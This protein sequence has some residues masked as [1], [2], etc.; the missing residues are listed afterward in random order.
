ITKG[1]MPD[2]TVAKNKAT[3]T[4]VDMAAFFDDVDLKQHSMV[5]FHT[6]AGNINVELF[7]DTA[8]QTVANF[9]N[10]VTSNQ[11]DSSIF[12]RLPTGFVLQGGG[13]SYNEDLRSITSI[14]N[15]PSVQNEFDGVNRSNLQGTIAMAKLPADAPG[16]GPNSATNQ[17]FFNLAN[18]AG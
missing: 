7:D 5:R 14:F 11:Y 10:Y 15:G 18:N 4:F 8:P 1:T 12:H 13:F 6:S 16:G 3:D 9:L 2:V 17:F